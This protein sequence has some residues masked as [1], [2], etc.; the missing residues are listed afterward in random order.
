MILKTLTLLILTA[1]VMASVACGVMN[2]QYVKRGTCESFGKEIV[3]SQL[4][5]AFGAGSEILKI[6]R[7]T[8]ISRTE[9]TVS[10]KGQAR[11]TSGDIDL[12]YSVEIDE[13]GEVWFEAREDVSAIFEDLEDLF[14]GLY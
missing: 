8:E 12:L 6:Y 14:E 3:G 10:C 2:S 5:N 11:T 1:I 13:D 9:T 7:T 4:T